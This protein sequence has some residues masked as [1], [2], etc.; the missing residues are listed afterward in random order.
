[1]YCSDFMNSIILFNDVLQRLSR[2]TKPKYAS[3]SLRARQLLLMRHQQPFFERTLAL[4]NLFSD[5]VER[6]YPLSL[7]FNSSQ[8]IGNLTAV[9]IIIQ[10][11]FRVLKLYIP[12][13]FFFHS[14]FQ[15]CHVASNL[16]HNNF[17]CSFHSIPD[18]T[19]VSSM[20]PAHHHNSRYV[21]A[22]Q[23][24]HSGGHMVVS[25]AL[26]SAAGSL[27]MTPIAAT[28]TSCGVENLNLGIFS[29]N[30]TGVT[31]CSTQTLQTF[32]DDWETVA[33]DSLISLLAHPN[34]QFNKLALQV[35][36]R[37]HFEQYGLH[38]FHMGYA[39]E[40]WWRRAL[41]TVPLQDYKLIRSSSKHEKNLEFFPCAM[42]VSNSKVIDSTVTTSAQS[43]E[44]AFPPVPP[45]VPTLKKDN[46][47]LFQGSNS[48]ENIKASEVLK[49][50]ETKFLLPSV[51]AGSRDQTTL[52]T[53]GLQRVNRLLAV[54]MCSAV[55]TY[56][57]LTQCC[58][59]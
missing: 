32:V 24:M 5:L 3:V 29:L 2:L 10:L 41:S 35:F 13:H 7:P 40:F 11:Q 4:T 31:D 57:F 50:T 42:H 20:I 39:G 26:R 16:N 37:R 53:A 38:E 34:P 27:G 52:N 23:R 15:G 51:E 14:L 19:I 56:D 1:M 22:L 36:V 9:R 21:N 6:R 48:F 28:H 58:D 54:W 44:T 59:V 47:D 17:N 43:L 30:P 25:P 33:D 18:N 49:N 45:L 12:K 55:L 46:E 8:K